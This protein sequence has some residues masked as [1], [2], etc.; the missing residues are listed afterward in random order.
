MLMPMDE[1]ERELFERMTRAQ[2]Q[3]SR[4]QERVADAVEKQQP[5]KLVQV[6]TTA[7]AI[8]TAVGGLSIVQMVINWFT[9]G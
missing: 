2:E 5:G 7:A 8:G 4:A 3:M 6:L 9:G 1:A